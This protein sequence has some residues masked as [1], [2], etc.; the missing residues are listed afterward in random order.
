[1]SEWEPRFARSGLALK[2]KGD[3]RAEVIRFSKWENPGPRTFILWDAYVGDRCIYRAADE[4]KV[5]QVIKV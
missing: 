2:Q 4:F 3:H 1:M 5:G